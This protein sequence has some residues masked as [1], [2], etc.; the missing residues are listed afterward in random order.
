MRSC[1]GSA[2]CVSSAGASERVENAGGEGCLRNPKRDLSHH[3][4]TSVNQRPNQ[5]LVFPP[6]PDLSAA[7]EV[8]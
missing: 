6:D 1:S 8:L 3:F 7:L 4:Q 2:G 5:I